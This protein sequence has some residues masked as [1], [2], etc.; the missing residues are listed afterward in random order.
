MDSTL[1]CVTLG[2]WHWCSRPVPKWSNK[3]TC[4]INLWGFNKVV[5]TCS[6][7]QCS[8]NNRWAIDAS[9]YHEPCMVLRTEGNTGCWKP[10]SPPTPSLK[11]PFSLSEGLWRIILPSNGGEHPLPHPPA[12][13]EAAVTS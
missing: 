6:I 2:K 10:P 1:F 11:S 9:C 5:G 4:F 7:K 13:L 8:A 3:S 12:L